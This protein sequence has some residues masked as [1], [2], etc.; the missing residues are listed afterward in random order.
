MDHSVVTEIHSSRDTQNYIHQQKVKQLLRTAV[1]GQEI[2]P[3]VS[4]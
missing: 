2:V 1:L 4:F 3:Q